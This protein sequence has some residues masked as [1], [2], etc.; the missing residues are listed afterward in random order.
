MA[1][2]DLPTVKQF[3][4]IDPS[5]TSQDDWLTRLVAGANAAVQSYCKRNLE[6]QSYTD[7]LDGNGLQVLPLRQYPVLSVTAVY[8][9]PAGFYGQGVNAFSSQTLLTVGRD[10]VP[11]FGPDSGSRSNS[12]LL[13]RLGGGISGTTLD[14]IWPW[15][16]RKG[17]LTARLPPVWPQGV[18]NVKVQF[19]AGLGTNPAASGGTLPEDLTLAACMVVAFLRRS[20]PPGGPVISETLGGYSYS[21]EGRLALNQSPEL[22]EARQLL[23]RFRS[24]CL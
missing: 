3:L 7:Y 16:W 17:T 24:V 6:T 19:S 10:Y 22:G 8:L 23:S 13:V 15:E 12:G 11:K 2:L 1:I 14:A 9:D 18:G 4:N 21:L 5:V 20:G